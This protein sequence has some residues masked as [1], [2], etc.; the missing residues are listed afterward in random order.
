[1]II[2]DGK[3]RFTTIQETQNKTVSLCFYESKEDLG[4]IEKA[5]A[6]LEFPN[7][8]SLFQWTIL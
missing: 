7:F 1:M 8:K 4:N 6:I 5:V 2:I 3:T